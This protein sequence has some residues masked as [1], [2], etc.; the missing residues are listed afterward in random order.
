MFGFVPISPMTHDAIKSLPTWA[1]YVL[2]C[3][4]ISFLVVMCIVPFKRWLDAPWQGSG[5]IGEAMGE[6][7]SIN[8]APRDG[9]LIRVRQGQ[10]LP[11]H[12][13]WVDGRWQYIEFQHPSRPT[14][15]APLDE[16]DK[17]TVRP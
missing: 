14:H 11:C 6:W 9:R 10:W 12:A 5:L 3:C 13:R 2:L 8:T 7:K 1:V 15:W 16:P 4:W 17:K